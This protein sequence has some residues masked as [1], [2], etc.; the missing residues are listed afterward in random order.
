MCI[1]EIVMGENEIMRR[2]TFMAENMFVNF[3]ELRYKE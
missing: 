1:F 2:M 3:S